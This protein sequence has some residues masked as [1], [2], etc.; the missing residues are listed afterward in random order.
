MEA[1]T[2]AGAALLMVSH[3][4]VVGLRFPDRLDLRDVARTG[5]GEPA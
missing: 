2:E 3:D 4:P 1:V 5:T